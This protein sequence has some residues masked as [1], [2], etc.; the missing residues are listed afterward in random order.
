MTKVLYHYHATYKWTG[1]TTDI[2]GILTLGRR[3][4]T[5]QDYR[6][7]K[8][9][10]LDHSELSHIAPDKLTICSLGFLGESHD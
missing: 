9:M 3:I 1:G 4:E 7:C 5:M 8:K 6:L 10:I 2:D